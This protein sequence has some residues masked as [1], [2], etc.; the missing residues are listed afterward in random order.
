MSCPRCEEAAAAADKALEEGLDW[1]SALTRVREILG[2]TDAVDLFS[3]D[4][5]GIFDHWNSK[6]NT[7]KHRSFSPKMKSAVRARRKVFSADELKK[8]ID[9]FDEMAGAGVLL[10]VERTWT[11]A[12]FLQKDAGSNV[13]R[14]LDP[15][16]QGWGMAGRSGTKRDDAERFAEAKPTAAL[17]C[18]ACG[19]EFPPGTRLPTEAMEIK[20]RWA[21]LRAVCPKCEGTVYT[22]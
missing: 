8:A 1:W 3:G 10:G 9:R 14:F 18:S 12:N 13:E 19:A 4:D 2:S 20:G 11:L 6:S 5:E 17:K 16:F 15:K 21:G 22:V 7:M